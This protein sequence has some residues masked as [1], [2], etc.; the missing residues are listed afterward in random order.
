MH[1]E[2]VK[3]E[4]PERDIP[5]LHPVEKSRDNLL[6][7][8]CRKRRGKP[9][10][11]R[12]CR[13][14]RR[15]SCQGSIPGHCIFRLIS[16][17]YIVCQALPLCRELH[18]LHLLTSDFKGDIPDMVDQDAIAP[19][20][21]IKRNILICNLTR[22]AA[23][24]IPHIHVLP[25]FHKRGEP[26]AQSVNLLIYVQHQ[27]FRHIRHPGNAVGHMRHIPVSAP[28]EQPALIPVIHLPRAGFFRYHCLQ[29]PG[30]IDEPV[31]LLCHFCP[32]IL[33]VHFKKRTLSDRPSEMR[34]F[35]TYHIFPRACKCNRKY[36]RIHRVPLSADVHAGRIHAEPTAL[37]SVIAVFHRVDGLK[38]LSH[39]PGT[40]GKFHLTLPPLLLLSGFYHSSGF[41]SHLS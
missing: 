21:D 9:E 39:K 3:V 25:V 24:L 2:T 38:L 17:D 37:H 41:L 7:I 36:R 29:L 5:F 11:E 1:P 20:A 27:L 18:A 16:P 34:D 40:V 23:V 12:P 10:T 31:I 32:D 35:R 6:I 4:Y 15:T 26:F 33:R 8:I 22:R 30:T 19:A 13:R 14:K 28:R